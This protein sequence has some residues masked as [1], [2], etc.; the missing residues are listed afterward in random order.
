MTTAEPSRSLLQYVT[1]SSAELL[2]RCPL[3]LSFARAAP[4]VA[5]GSPATW[6]G[7]AAHFSL[8]SLVKER[9]LWLENP[10]DSAV[11]AFDTEV[12][13]LIRDADDDVLDRFGRDP[14]RW[15]GFLL[16]RARLGKVAA[17]LARRLSAVSP[18]EVFPEFDYEAFGG[19]MRGRA[20]LVVRAA[21]LHAIADYK[22]GRIL[23]EEHELLSTYERQIRLYCAMEDDQTG[24]FPQAGWLVPF[25]GPMVDVEIDR[26][27]CRTLAER[28]ID[29]LDRFNETAAQSQ[30]AF[31]SKENCSTCPYAPICPEFWHAPNDGLPDGSEAVR[32]VVD[33]VRRVELGGV[34]L[35]VGTTNSTL[36]QTDSILVRNIDMIVFP[37]VESVAQGDMVAMV[38]LVQE[39]DRETYRLQRSG[40]I[41]VIAAD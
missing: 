1:P 25:D 41:R 33:Q 36:E 21:S 9:G 20:D 38:G 10:A 28:A 14:K 18:D 29:A 26:G 30:P 31:V 2:L 16:K 23:N 19:R 7:N 8:E 39:R 40:H 35:Q 37:G 27:V 6:I 22:T 34:T 24:S 12:A 17:R 3:R 4:F 11:R 15:P 5:L 32:G 13:R